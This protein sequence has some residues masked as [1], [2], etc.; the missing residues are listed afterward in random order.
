[1]LTHFRNDSAPWKE[2]IDVKFGRVMVKTNQDTIPS[3]EKPKAPHMEE[4]PKLELTP[5]PKMDVEIPAIP[6]IP[7][8]PP[9]PIAKFNFPNIDVKVQSDSLGKMARE[10]QEIEDDNSPEAKER[11]Q[12]LKSAMAKV[13]QNIEELAKVFEVKMEN[14]QKAHGESF[15]KFENDMKLWEEKMKDHGKEWESSFAPK[16]KELEEKMK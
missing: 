3:K 4:M 13:K 9:A 15:E 7:P 16:M 2:P 12:T 5:A 14:W 1:L 8:V 11:R 10:L 6:E